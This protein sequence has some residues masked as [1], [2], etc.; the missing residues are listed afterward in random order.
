M[1]GRSNFD[2]LGLLSVGFFFRTRFG[3]PIFT[4]I[5][6]GLVTVILRY[7]SILGIKICVIDLFGSLP[8]R[9]VVVTHWTSFEALLAHVGLDSW[10]TNESKRSLFKFYSDHLISKLQWE[11]FFF[12]GSSSSKTNWIY[13]GNERKKNSVNSDS[14]FPWKCAT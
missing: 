3:G 6:G 10:I 8:R 5:V 4:L 11:P 13:T 9:H 14:C 2:C 12:F 1:V 7:Y